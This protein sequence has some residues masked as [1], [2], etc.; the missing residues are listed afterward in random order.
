MYFAVK[1]QQVTTSKIG[2]M[3]LELKSNKNVMNDVFRG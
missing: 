1:V 2:R 3:Y